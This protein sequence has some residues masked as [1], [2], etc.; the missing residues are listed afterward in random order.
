MQDNEISQQFE[1]APILSVI[2]QKWLSSP[3]KIYNCLNFLT[4]ENITEEK[5]LSAVRV[6]SNHLLDE[7]PALSNIDKKEVNK[8]NAAQWLEE[9]KEKYG[10]MFSLK[11]L[12][13]NSKIPIAIPQLNRVKE[14]K[15]FKES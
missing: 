4:G 11:P 3:E 12:P 6:C 9:Q 7:L 13:E 14:L 1:L 10:D 8:D 5:L 15:K 2:T